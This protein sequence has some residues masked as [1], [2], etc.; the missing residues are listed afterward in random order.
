[1]K[2]FQLMKDLYR[3]AANR[4]GVSKLNNRLQILQ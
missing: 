3:I 2:D 4:F 1:M